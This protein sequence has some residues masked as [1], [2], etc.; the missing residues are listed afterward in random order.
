MAEKLP[1]PSVQ[2]SVSCAVAH[3]AANRELPHTYI[4]YVYIFD[5]YTQVCVHSHVHMCTHICVYIY[6][7][8]YVCIYIYISV[9][10]VLS[11]RPKAT[12]RRTHVT[13]A[14]EPSHYGTHLACGGTL[15]IG[16]RI[17]TRRHAISTLCPSALQRPLH[18][19]WLHPLHSLWLHLPRRRL[20]QLPSRQ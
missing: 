8:M 2:S 10:G 16:I 1:T 14:D 19:L 5:M 18:S 3:S 20:C 7:N 9:L 11:L 17:S 15:S 13:H 4:T 6:S 12:I